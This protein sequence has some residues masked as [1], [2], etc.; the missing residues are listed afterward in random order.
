[1]SL[2]ETILIVEDEDEWCGIYQRAIRAHRPGHPVR[3]ANDLAT[4]ERLIEEMT[5]AVAFVDIGLDLGDSRNV[6]GL[7]VM[8]KIRAA[9]GK[10]S[11]VVV[12]GMSSRDMTPA[13]RTALRKYG[14]AESARK[15]SIEPSDIGRLLEEGLDAYQRSASGPPVR[16]DRP[17]GPRR[18][19]PGPAPA[20]GSPR[21]AER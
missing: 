3:V 21:T 15:N 17:P 1:M 6:D 13:V 14:V 12:T 18:S 10:T 9:S 20:P 2:S 19:P 7:R 4:A 11:I 8:E 16:P 5:F